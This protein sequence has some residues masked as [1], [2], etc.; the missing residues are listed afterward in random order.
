[1]A[2]E[3]EP[4]VAVGR[5]GSQELLVLLAQLRLGESL[6]SRR[7]PQLQLEICEVAAEKLDFEA[8]AACQLAEF[9]RPERARDRALGPVGC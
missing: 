4:S 9:G 2:L 8:C 3:A 5:N 6:R 7:P 1:M